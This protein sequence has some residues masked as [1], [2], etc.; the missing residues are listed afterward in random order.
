MLKLLDISEICYMIQR[1]KS[2]KLLT[3]KVSK[4]EA[5]CWKKCFYICER[6]VTSNITNVCESWYFQYVMNNL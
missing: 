5:N 2:H 4:K 6:L 1:L 3:D